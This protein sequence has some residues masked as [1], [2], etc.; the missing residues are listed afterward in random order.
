[1]TSAPRN[2]PDR[3]GHPDHFDIVRLILPDGTI[4]HSDQS[5]HGPS[6]PAGDGPCRT[7]ISECNQEGPN[8]PTGPEQNWNDGVART[9]D[10][11]EA[12]WD[13]ALDYA[14]KAGHVTT[15]PCPGQPSGDPPELDTISGR[16]RTWTGRVVSLEEW[17]RLTKWERF[18]P[19]GRHWNGNSRRW[20]HK[21]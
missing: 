3:S 7:N 16:P 14:S 8:G 9:P 21:E 19:N 15:P 10:A 2:R 17:R 20:E 4:D 1:M 6:G 12:V 18:G 13:D 11:I 5:D